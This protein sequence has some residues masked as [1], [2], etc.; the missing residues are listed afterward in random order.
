MACAY[1][2]RPGRASTA[3]DALRLIRVPKKRSAFRIAVD[4]R[5]DVCRIAS[6]ISREDTVVYG[7]LIGSVALTPWG[8]TILTRLETATRMANFKSVAF[9]HVLSA[10]VWPPAQTAI[11]QAGM[12]GVVALASP[13]AEPPPAPGIGVFGDGA[14][15]FTLRARAADG[16]LLFSDENGDVSGGNVA[17]WLNAHL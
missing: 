7:V 4:P 1:A 9:D 13:D 12:P 6:P 2:D 3:P 11:A 10:G 16:F 5:R 17:F 8:S 14:G 15:R